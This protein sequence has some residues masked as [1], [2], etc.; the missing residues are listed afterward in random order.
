[1]TL[2]QW[3][4][5]LFHKKSADAATSNDRHFDQHERRRILDERAADAIRTADARLPPHEGGINF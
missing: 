5:R 2:W 3:I 4:V 1:M